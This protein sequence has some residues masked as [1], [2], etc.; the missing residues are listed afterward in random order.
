MPLLRLSLALQPE[1]N[2]R[3][4]LGLT[5]YR[6]NYGGEDIGFGTVRQDPSVGAD[7]VATYA[8]DARWTLRGEA[9]WSRNTSN[10]DLYDSS[11]KAASLKLRYQY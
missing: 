7:L 1:P 5:T 6:Q 8:M 4:A 3:L 2:L 11:R 10:Q 9:Q